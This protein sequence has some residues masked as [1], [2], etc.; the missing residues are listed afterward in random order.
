[1]PQHSTKWRV[2]GEPLHAYCERNGLRY[3]RVHRRVAYLGWSIESAVSVKE[4]ARHFSGKHFMET[5]RA[6]IAAGR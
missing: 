2:N 5:Y 3:D 6:A 4:D 1:M